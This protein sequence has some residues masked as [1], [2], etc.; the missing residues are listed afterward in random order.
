ML[1][2][3]SQ[4]IVGERIFYGQVLRVMGTRFEM[5]IANVDTEKGERCWALTTTELQRLDKMLNR[6]DTTSEVSRANKRAFINPF[7]VSNEFWSIL[8]DCEK[9]YKLTNGF[10]D[11]TLRDFSQLKFFPENQSIS[12]LIPNLSLDFGG[13]AKG[14]ALEKIRQILKNEKIE[15]AFINF[16]NSS[17]LALGRHPYGDSWKVNVENPF[18]AGEVLGEFTLND[19]ILTTSGNSP[20]YTEHIINPISGKRNKERKC[21]C[22]VTQNACDG[23]VLSTSLIAST[24]DEKHKIIA[25]FNVEKL[26]EYNL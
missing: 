1:E 4:Y 16:G 14:Y 24:F 26:A 21:V 15:H 8:K 10:F 7:V 12:F 3:T 23:E 13:Y 22:V 18:L 20:G 19:S 17:I 2:V 9:Y 5:L 11:V 25:N 6:F